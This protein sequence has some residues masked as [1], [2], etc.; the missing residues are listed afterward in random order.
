M[1]SDPT[2]DVHEENT[3]DLAVPVPAPAT[4]DLAPPD[5]APEIVERPSAWAMSAEREP[6]KQPP[7]P[8][9]LTTSEPAAEP[10]I[11]TTRDIPPPL[12]VRMLRT[13]EPTRP[14]AVER[15]A[16]SAP[17]QRPA[18]PA[19]QPAALIPGAV[20][21]D[22]Y[23]L[24]QVVGCGGTSVVFRA[25]D[26]LSSTTAAPNA[27][28]AI[29]TPR[30]EMGHPARAA[31]RLKYEFEH[32]RR[33]SHPNIVRVFD[34]QEDAGRRFI[35]MEL[36][37][38]KLLSDLVRDWTIVPVQLT[39]KIL[40]ACAD[41]LSHAHSRDVV[42]GDFKPGNVFITSDED[43]RIVDFGAAVAPS[44]ADD[45][46]IPAGTPAYAS[47]QVLSGEKPDPRDD[48]FS[49][50]CVAYELL[51]GQ[52]PFERVSSLQARDE[53]RIPPRA[54]NL[55]TAQWLS[56]VS[57]LSWQREQ[58]PADIQMLMARLQPKPPEVAATQAT[59]VHAPSEELMPADLPADLI[60][61]Q[62]SW[63]FFAFVACALFVTYLAV[64]HRNDVDKH[65][66]SPASAATISHAPASMTPSAMPGAMPA[67]TTATVVEEAMGSPAPASGHPS[68][69]DES[70]GSKSSIG[71][72]QHE[73]V[74]APPSKAAA[75]SSSSSSQA[76]APATTKPA[77]RASPAALSE[78]SFESRTVV[79]SESSVAAVFLIKRSQPLR[80][81]VRVSW[82]AVSGTAD[83]GIDFASN[84]SGT[85]EFADGQAQRAIYV[86]LRNDLLK[87]GDETFTVRLSSPQSARLGAI[88]QAEAI[89]RDDD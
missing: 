55:S 23:L 88:S 64:Q 76:V 12:L 11:L 56:L 69:L 59:P 78:I 67:S 33:L 51:T 47:P 54:W 32:A 37:E 72:P 60:P 15:L 49:F 42:H 45:T 22:R 27:R 4:E 24:E 21:C 89:I 80:G 16:P 83:A 2:T 28:V 46:R 18:S 43:V 26:M 61:K 14:A 85:V 68:I 1:D 29:K 77:A 7:E 53:Q 6:S 79:T 34:L 52:H 41:A 71:K 13:A 38:G 63:G 75:S 50:A 40:H 9:V 73:E 65:V 48:V 35:T 81:R 39:H 5:V 84:A 70:P 30:P 58:R 19:A 86:P 74:A 62:R 66:A 36:I 10:P 25:R 8:P 31:L 44:A 3:E 57:G 87:E 20:L 17:V 82:T